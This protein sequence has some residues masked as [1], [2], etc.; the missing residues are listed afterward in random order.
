M[1]TT[2]LMEIC[3]RYDLLEYILFQ[4]FFSALF[5]L[6]FYLHN[7]YLITYMSSID[8]NASMTK[9]TLLS[10]SF[11]TSVYYILY[12]VDIQANIR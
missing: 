11:F 10:N 6:Q 7:L 8:I 2:G 3:R 1:E 12:N 4:V 5:N 9:H